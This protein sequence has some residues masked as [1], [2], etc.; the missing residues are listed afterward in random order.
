[1][2]IKYKTK[3]YVVYVDDNFHYMDESE[4]YCAGEF[5]IPEDA[6][7]KCI[8]IVE[9]SLEGSAKIENN[10][11]ALYRSYTMFGDDPFIIGSTSVV[12]S[13]WDYARKRCK[14]IYPIK[15][16]KKIGGSHD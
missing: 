5:D 4:R 7:T 10:A 13:A 1:M 16:H 8:E 12:F 6:I 14:E 2:K 15:P 3:K 9:S 11:D